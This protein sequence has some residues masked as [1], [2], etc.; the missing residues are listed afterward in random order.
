MKIYHYTDQK[1][2]FGMQT[3][4]IDGKTSERFEDFTGLIPQLRFIPIGYGLPKEA[5]RDVSFAFIEKEPKSWIKYQEF[6]ENTIQHIVRGEKLVILS[7]NLKPSDIAYIVD[8]IFFENE[9]IKKESNWKEGY[10]KYWGSRISIHDYNQNYTLPMVIIEN[11][12]KFK[13]LN[14][15][16]T[17]DKNEFLTFHNH[18]LA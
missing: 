16:L 10:E 17:V 2:Y 13:R 7:F 8:R 15:E 18:P 1:A 12:I 4:G 6:W 3:P 5:T 14:L 9:R 11:G